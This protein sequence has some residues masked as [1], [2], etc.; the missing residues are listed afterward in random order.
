MAAEVLWV[1]FLACTEYPVNTVIVFV[2]ILW[3]R[4]NN[5]TPGFIVLSKGRDMGNLPHARL[6]HG[7]CRWF[8]YATSMY[9]RGSTL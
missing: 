3:L 2:R 7:N 6:A 5:C 1:D 8:W 9:G 4:H